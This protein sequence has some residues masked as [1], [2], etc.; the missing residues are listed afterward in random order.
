LRVGVLRDGYYL[1]VIGDLAP[2]A[3]A[4]VIDS[5]AE[6][7]DSGLEYDLLRFDQ[8]TSTE[9]LLDLNH[10]LQPTTTTTTSSS[11]AQG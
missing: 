10:V 1:V 7:G 3:W 5:Q 4:Q 2:P 9:P 8:Q 6:I 11:L